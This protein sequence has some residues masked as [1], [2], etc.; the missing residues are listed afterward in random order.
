MFVLEKRMLNGGKCGMRRNEKEIGNDLTKGNIL[1]QLLAFSSPIVLTNLVQQ[2]YSMVDLAVIG[3]YVGSIG[4][5]GVA[6]GG[7]VADFMS[8]VAMGLSTAGQ[9]Y[10]AQIIGAKM[11]SKVKKSIG[12]LIT[13]MLLISF[14]LMIAAI[15]F[16]EPILNALNCPVEAMDQAKSYMIITA[17]GYPFIF[18]YNA[19]VGCLRGMGESKH[20]LEFI[21]I[22]AVINIFADI[23][24]VKYCSLEA[25]GTAIATV[26][27]QLGSFLASFIFMYRNREHFDFEL[28]LSYFKLDGHDTKILLKLAVPQIVR[29]TFVRFSMLWVNAN[30]NAYGL[31][32]SA[33]NSIGTKIQKF[34]EVFVQGVDTASSA[35]IGQNLGAHEYDRASKT[36]WTTLACCEI[37]AVICCMFCLVMPQAI[38]GT[39]TSD[40]NV[41]EAGTE[42]LRILC[43]HFVISAF[44][45]TF[46]AM[47]TGSGFV[48]L[49]FVL[50]ILDGVVCRIGFSLMFLYLFHFGY[51]SYWWGTAFA[52]VLT[53]AL[54]FA[55]FISGKWKTRELLVE[56]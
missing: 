5:V 16:C 29:S 21:S 17:V 42:Y 31:T 45:A 11:E 37:L 39:L 22:A 40:L 46:Q 7:E 53:G 13:L 35:M 30:V 19:V 48:S 51:Q 41:I 8:P 26:L 43:F 27:S 32:V 28:K 10:I 15:V 1:K 38:L 33:A 50:G 3:K 44:T 54:C 49:G 25:A 55:Y 23:F 14:V 9:I 20:P 2:L 12:T 56:Q 36:V 4:S 18:G 6:T 34:M 24:F 47:V 52:R